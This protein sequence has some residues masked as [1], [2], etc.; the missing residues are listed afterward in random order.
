MI[1]PKNFIVISILLLVIL[2]VAYFFVYPRFSKPH[3]LVQLPTGPSDDV[4]MKEVKEQ[5]IYPF[6]LTKGG[7]SEED[8]S[9]YF[10]KDFIED[11]N[12]IFSAPKDKVFSQ[13]QN[14]LDL[15]KENYEDM[16]PL[17]YGFSCEDFFDSNSESGRSIAKMEWFGLDKGN[18]QDDIVRYLY[19]Y[20]PFPAY[21]LHIRL[22]NEDNTWKIDN[23]GSSRVIK[24]IKNN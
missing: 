24:M 9:K 17:R 23:V 16:Y 22:V 13:P 3:R 8:F 12:R 5:L 20:E 14:T 7:F 10:S 4:T 18:Y 1:K 15:T 2:T 21:Q 6:C 11:S 19:Y